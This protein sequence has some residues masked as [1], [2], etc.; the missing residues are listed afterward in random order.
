MTVNEDMQMLAKLAHYSRVANFSDK[1]ALSHRP[2][3][4]ATTMSVFVR[5]LAL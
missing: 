3:N 4:I 2:S 1:H 5:A